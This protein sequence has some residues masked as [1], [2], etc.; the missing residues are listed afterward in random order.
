MA[1]VVKDVGAEESP[2]SVMKKGRVWAQITQ[3]RVNKKSG[4]T[5]YCA[6]GDYC[7]DSSAIDIVTPCRIV[8]TAPAFSSLEEDDFY[9][10]TQ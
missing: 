3:V 7:Y 1:K 9:L 8:R 10:G 6:H 4:K 2:S 5:T